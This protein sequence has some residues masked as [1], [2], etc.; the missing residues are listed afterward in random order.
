MRIKAITNKTELDKYFKNKFFEKTSKKMENNRKKI[1]FIL[2]KKKFI[3]K[4]YVI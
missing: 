2:R 3:S 1:P 4:T